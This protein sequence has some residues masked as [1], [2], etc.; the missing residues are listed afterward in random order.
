MTTKMGC[1]SNINHL[2]ELAQEALKTKSAKSYSRRPVVIEFCGSPKS[3]K[4]SCLKSLDVF[5]RRNGFKT[6]IISEKA[7]NCPITNKHSPIF[8]LWT[9][10]RSI[11]DLCEMLY[12]RRHS[13]VD[14]ILC[15]RPVCDALCWLEWMR[16]RGALGDGEFETIA[17]FVTLPFWTRAI[18]IVFVLTADP[19]DSIARE[20]AHLLTRKRESIMNEKSVGGPTVG[21]RCGG[22]SARAAVRTSS[23][24]GNE[25]FCARLLRCGWAGVRA[26]LCWSEAQVLS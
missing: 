16:T 15:D 22:P 14:I 19:S 9:V 3:G 23:V 25:G 26:V 6:Y 10:M 17:N 20:Y 12:D 13:D 18:D 2:E 5:L 7:E 21:R 1:D 8:N 11:A 24:R 4:T